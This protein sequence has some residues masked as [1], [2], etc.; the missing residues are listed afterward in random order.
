MERHIDDRTDRT[1]NRTDHHS[2]NHIESQHLDHHRGDGHGES[3]EE[4]TAAA[5]AALST[6]WGLILPSGF[7]SVADEA[8]AADPRTPRSGAPYGQPVPAPLRVRARLSARRVLLRRSVL[9]GVAAIAALVVSY[10]F[11]G[12]L[13]SGRFQAL[14]EFLALGGAVVFLVTAVSAVRAGTNDALGLIRVPGRLGDARAGTFRLVCLLAGYIVVVLCA[15]ALVHVP[16]QHLLLGGVLTGVILGIAAQQ[17]LANLFAGIMLLF[18]RPF[19]IGDELTVRSGALGGPIIGRVTG[20][21]LTYVTVVT[22]AG[23]VLI[24]NSSVLAAAIGPA[25]EWMAG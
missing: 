23:P 9:A 8:A 17:V 1:D 11:G 16:V 18:A 15:L 25:K 2:D 21:T 14:H 6:Q 13:G 19:T 24:P 5:A 22:P 10:H 4:R 20:M 7:S 3:S 12:L